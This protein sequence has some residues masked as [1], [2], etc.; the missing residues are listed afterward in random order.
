MVV[1]SLRPQ[2]HTNACETWWPHFR[3]FT[4]TA[5][6]W[7]FRRS[8]LHHIR[9]KAQYPAWRLTPEMKTTKHKLATS[10]TADLGSRADI[11]K[12][13]TRTFESLV[14]TVPEMLC[15]KLAPGSVHP[16]RTTSSPRKNRR[17]GL[18]PSLPKLTPWTSR[19]L[20]HFE[21][22]LRLQLGPAP[23]SPKR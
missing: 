23:V 14:N 1:A 9:N 4:L 22:G 21:A 20:A 15:W 17:S 6:G 7:I 10:E 3:S 11:N 8:S 19:A 2:T 12:S 5:L 18:H 16:T 13:S